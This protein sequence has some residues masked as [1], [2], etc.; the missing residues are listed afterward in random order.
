M[1]SDEKLHVAIIMDGNGRWAQ[2][3]LLP[4]KMGH[5]EGVKTLLDIAEYAFSKGIDTLTVYAFSTENKRRPEDEVSALIDLIRK[6]F[7]TT[8][9]RITQKGIR[10]RVI[11]D[12]SY[13][14]DD[15]IEILDKAENDSKVGKNGTFNVA[16]NYGG[17]DE[18]VRAATR[19]ANSG[20]EITE[21]SFSDAL[22]T[23]DQPDPDILIRTGGEKRLSNFLLYQCAYTELFFVDTLWPDFST[24]ELDE[25]LQEFSKRNR[26]YGKVL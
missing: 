10:L 5:K 6:N 2:K 1:K 7:A 13:F 19:L 17:R 26:R 22:Y 24:K 9:K 21:Q 16:L 14:P 25:I 18:I 11:G 15:V 4:R 12:K 8:F 20:R 3:R 23:A